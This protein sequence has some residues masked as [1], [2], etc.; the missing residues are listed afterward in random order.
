MSNFIT[1]NDKT[2]I[3][4]S[5]LLTRYSL[6]VEEIKKYLDKFEEGIKKLE[7]QLINIKLGIQ[8]WEE[9]PNNIKKLEEL[10]YDSKETAQDL[11]Y[12]YD[13]RRLFIKQFVDWI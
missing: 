13:Y 2:K 1:I 5:S 4:L 8:Y 3:F 6:P 11:I 12:M 7:L 10:Y 9:E